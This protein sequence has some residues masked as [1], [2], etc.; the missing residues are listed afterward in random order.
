MTNP[1]KTKS[2]DASNGS[3]RLSEPSITPP[4][5]PGTVH[6]VESVDRAIDILA[7]DL[8]IHAENCVRQ[9]G[10]FHIA[11]SGGSTPQPLYERL[12]YDPNYRRLPWRRTHLWIVDERCV[13]PDDPQSNWRM[14]KETIVDHADIPAEQVHP[15]PALAPDG[16][17]QYEKSLRDV[18]GWREKGQDRLDFVLLGMGG[19]AHTAS[20]FPGTPALNETNR[21]VVFNVSPVAAPHKRI[22][23]TFPLLNAA[24]FIAVLVAGKSK[25]SAIHQIAQGNVAPEHA[26][27]TGIK[28]FNGELHWYLDAD[29]CSQPATNS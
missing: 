19:D 15:M 8:V 24:R 1:S 11:L 26:P 2:H 27:I 21:L 3:Y 5:L 12:M 18:L 28:P 20:L 23:M 22:T 10:D 14:I 9:F 16:D 13:P 17:V 7:A 6:A 4:N 29:A 25:A